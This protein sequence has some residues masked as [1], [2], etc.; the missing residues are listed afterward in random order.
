MKSAAAARTG[1]R[2]GVFGVR[3]NEKYYDEKREIGLKKMTQF[4]FQGAEK[5]TGEWNK[6]T[7]EGFGTQVRYLGCTHLSRA[8]SFGVPTLSLPCHPCAAHP[9]SS[10]GVDERTQVRRRV[11]WW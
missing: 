7:K 8:V 3:P 5:Y 2:K 1:T 11:D 4:P 6:N 9:Y 10:A